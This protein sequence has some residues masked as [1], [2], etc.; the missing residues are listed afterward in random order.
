MDWIESVAKPV[1]FHGSLAFPAAVRSIPRQVE[2]MIPAVAMH[3][4]GG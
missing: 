4:N 1:T 2:V 3:W